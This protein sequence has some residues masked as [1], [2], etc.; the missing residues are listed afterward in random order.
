M[1]VVTKS[2]PLKHFFNKNDLLGCLEKWVMMLIEFGLIFI[3][4]REIK[5]KDLTDHLVEAPL[6]YTTLIVDSFPDE[7][8]LMIENI[9]GNYNLMD[10]NVE[11]A[12]V[13]ELY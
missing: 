5:V 11:L 1:Q 6:I 9:H 7:N 8:V 2:N 3:T 13:Q 10:L 4:Q 12:L